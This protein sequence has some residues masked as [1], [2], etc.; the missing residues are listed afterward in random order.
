VAVTISR[1]D[2][3]TREKAIAVIEMFI[4]DDDDDDD[5]Q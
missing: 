3:M 4:D 2:E 1:Q 5:D